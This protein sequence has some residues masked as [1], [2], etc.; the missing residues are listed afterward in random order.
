MVVID[1]IAKC[2]GHF[3]LISAI[4]DKNNK[5]TK[6]VCKLEMILI[7]VGFSDVKQVKTLLTSIFNKSSFS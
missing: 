3:S 6:I 2:H 7:E 4:V 1:N 5:I